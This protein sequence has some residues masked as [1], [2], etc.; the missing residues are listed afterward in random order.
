MRMTIHEPVGALGIVLFAGV[1]TSAI[2]SAVT[3]RILSR[4][5]AGPLIAIGAAAIGAT[6]TAEAAA[7]ALWVVTVG[8]GVNWRWAFGTMAVRRSRCWSGSGDGAGCSPG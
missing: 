1:V 6:L 7:P 5:A 3:G 8:S 2:S 4:M